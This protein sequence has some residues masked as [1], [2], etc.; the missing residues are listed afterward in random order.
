MGTQQSI[1][2][3]FFGLFRHLLELLLSRQ[4]VGQLGHRVQLGGMDEVV[5]VVDSAE[6]GGGLASR[7]VLKGEGG[8]ELQHILVPLLD[9]FV[10]CMPEGWGL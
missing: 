4:R 7:H 1:N 8:Q 6:V 10:W 9:L 2:S 3:L 5:K